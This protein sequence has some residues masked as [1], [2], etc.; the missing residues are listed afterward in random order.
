MIQLD[1]LTADQV[2]RSR[3]VLATDGNLAHL[4]W[5]NLDPELGGLGPVLYVQVGD[6]EMPSLD[7]V[8]RRLA[9]LGFQTTQEACFA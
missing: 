9:A 1:D 4:V 5:G 3:A 8:R 2:D 7:A 6:L